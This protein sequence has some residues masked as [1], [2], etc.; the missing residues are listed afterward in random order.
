MN[1]M[2]ANG[3]H[4]HCSKSN[5]P[6]TAIITATKGTLMIMQNNNV[7]GNQNFNSEWTTSEM[8]LSAFVALHGECKPKQVATTDGGV[9]HSIDAADGTSALFSNKLESLLDE[10]KASGK[11]FQL[12]QSKLKIRGYHNLDTNATG[13]MAYYNSKADSEDFAL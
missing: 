10:A 11:K 13:F 9:R 5:R 1:L 7:A 8:T 12:D 2:I 6:N 4:W 3:R